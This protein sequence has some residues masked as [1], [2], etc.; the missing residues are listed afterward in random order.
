MKKQSVDYLHFIYRP[1]VE[2][3]LAVWHKRFPWAPILL[4]TG[5]M[6]AVLTFRIDLFI[7]K[8]ILPHALYPTVPF[9]YRTYSILILSSGFF[10]WSFF[11]TL[12]RINLVNTLTDV[13][14]NAGLRNRT[15]KLPNFVSDYPLDNVNRK[16]KVTSASFPKSKFEESKPYLESGLKIFIDEIKESRE[17]GMMEITYSHLSMPEV[18]N[19]EPE[20]AQRS[21]EFQI[22]RT[23]TEIKVS[24]FEE[25]PHL[26]V[27]GVSGKGKSTFLRQFIT[28]L[29]TQNKNTQFLLVDLKGG[30]EFQL[31]E[32]LPRVKIAGDLAE[33]TAELLL[34]QQELQKRFKKV[35]ELRAKD[36]ESYEKKLKAKGQ[37]MNL[38]RYVVV[39]DEIA[40]V[41]MVKN[42]SQGHDIQA[43]K[44]ALSQIS[45]LGR[46][47]G[48]HLVAATQR[49]DKQ[50]IDSQVKAN[51]SGKI[52]FA[53][54]DDQSSILILGNGR[55]TDL[56][57]IRGR[58]IWKDGTE[59]IE[60]QAPFMSEEMAVQIL[61]PF[62]TITKVMQENPNPEPNSSGYNLESIEKYD[63]N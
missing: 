61:A 59:M 40:E 27:A 4:W 63:S 32:D 1:I 46:A 12:L 45:R 49:P 28:H 55:A 18:V 34:I 38:F 26:L 42:Q 58:A 41:F 36:L 37:T 21:H 33:A 30:L 52:C 11:Q 10:G 20:F 17:R 19:Y 31:F 9:W 39:V 29:Y 48:I 44:S 3:A 50:A 25:N 16:L 57:N 51:L 8:K 24:N 56:P 54:S 7:W 14:T 35:R 47:V 60:V 15:G 43:A 2:L 6:M 13:F 53:M 22:G 62:R 23:R 5:I